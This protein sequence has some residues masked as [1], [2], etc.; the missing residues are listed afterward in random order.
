[1]FFFFK[2]FFVFLF[3]WGGSGTDR[4]GH[5]DRH[6]A[7]QW[8]Y[9]TSAHPLDGDPRIS[10]SLKSS[11]HRLGRGILASDSALTAVPYRGEL[12]TVRLDLTDGLSAPVGS[13][14][15]RSTSVSRRRSAA[16]FCWAQRA[17]PR[18][19][20]RRA[21]AATAE[22]RPPMTIWPTASQDHSVKQLARCK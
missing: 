10:R 9:L 18:H 22:P 20:Q 15:S 2:F 6:G 12:R 3:F 1:M 13:Y 11:A 16:H 19:A 8:R 17:P 5:S 21:S 4:V 14:A 7:C